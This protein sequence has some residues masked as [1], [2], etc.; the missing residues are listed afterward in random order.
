MQTQ[1]GYCQQPFF[2]EALAFVLTQHG[3]DGK[4]RVAGSDTKAGPAVSCYLSP[5]HAMMDAAY[6]M[7][8]GKRYNVSEIN[9][10]A[11][12]TFATA[13]G[14]ALVAEVRLGWP[15]IDG[16]IVLESDDNIATCS[17]LI[18]HSIPDGV[19]PFFGPDED[20]LAQI[21][22]LHELAGMFA[23]RDIYRDMLTWDKARMER[24]VTCAIDSME[25][26]TAKLADCQQ[27]ALFDPEFEQW[28]FVPFTETS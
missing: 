6:W 9:M 14:A 28:H 15:A 17:R 21:D 24:A 25:V 20:A 8:R 4:L 22:H 2:S 23:W 10:I 7:Y 13:N 12:E 5:V 19:P 1:S 18:A 3:D 16:K 11:P 26:S 27:I